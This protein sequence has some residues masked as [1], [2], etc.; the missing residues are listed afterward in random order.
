LKFKAKQDPELQLV[1]DTFKKEKYGVA[2]P[3]GSDLREKINIS[4]LEMQ[5]TPEYDEIYIKYF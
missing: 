3:K 4:L 1:G 5:S 2:F